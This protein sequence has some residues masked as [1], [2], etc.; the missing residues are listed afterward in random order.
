MFIER[1]ENEKQRRGCKKGRF[2]IRSNIYLELFP[3]SINV[4]LFE[5]A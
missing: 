1:K 4:N 5:F 2:Q 3:L